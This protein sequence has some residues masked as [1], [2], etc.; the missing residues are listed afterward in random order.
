M[1]CIKEIVWM[2]CLKK[3]VA[4]PL[5]PYNMVDLFRIVDMIYG[6][7]DLCLFFSDYVSVHLEKFKLI[8]NLSKD[9]FDV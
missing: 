5:F 8:V 7:E 3:V 1:T 6:G 2:I 4:T 9:A